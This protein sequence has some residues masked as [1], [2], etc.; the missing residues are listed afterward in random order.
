MRA[1][2]LL[3]QDAA[4]SPSRR[5]SAAVLVGV[6]GA[7]LVT[8]ALAVG[9]LR[10]SARAG[11]EQERFDAASAQLDVLG[12]APPPPS[13]VAA[14]L[15]DEQQA[16]LQAV[17]AVLTRRVAWDRVLRNVSLVI[18]EDVWLT[19]LAGTAPA[20]ATAQASP[21]AA[22]AESSAVPSGLTLTGFTYSHRAVARV[23][24]RIALLPDLRNVQ[25]QRS[26]RTEL[27]GRPVVTFTIA[28]DVRSGEEAA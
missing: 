22:P 2:N 3:P 16:R 5:P 9:L 15:G 1:V 6:I 12:P 11:E 14:G 27:G 21:T 24:A 17:S 26:A 18:P 7:V 8:F 4:R 28:A 10:T 23:L 13:A 19:N 20:A 25:L